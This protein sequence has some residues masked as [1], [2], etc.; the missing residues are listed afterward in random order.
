MPGVV[1]GHQRAAVR[2]K[3]ACL[4]LRL[5]IASF[6]P[7]ASWRKEGDLSF[8]LI[9]VGVDFVGFSS[10]GSQSPDS[11]L[12]IPPLLFWSCFLHPEA[13]ISHRPRDQ[14]SIQKSLI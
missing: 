6:Q 2:Y 3:G 5:H 8:S 12:H 14:F 4:E 11:F 13:Q 10:N 7:E 1:R 9:I